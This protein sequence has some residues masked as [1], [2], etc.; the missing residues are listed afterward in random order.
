MSRPKLDAHRTHVIST[1]AL[2]IF[3]RVNSTD[4]QSWRELEDSQGLQQFVGQRFAGRV[5]DHDGY[6]CS[7]EDHQLPVKAHDGQ[8]SVLSRQTK[9][10]TQLQTAP[11]RSR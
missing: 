6:R 4:T 11:S 5:A 1:Q 8:A 9:C 2:K 7:K 10:C 3:S